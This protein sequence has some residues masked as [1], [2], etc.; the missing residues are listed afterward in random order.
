MRGLGEWRRL[1]RTACTNSSGPNVFVEKVF[2]STPRL[3][4][5]RA[6]SSGGLAIPGYRCHDGFESKLN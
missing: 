1:G 5:S 2:S 6:S 3:I 4:V